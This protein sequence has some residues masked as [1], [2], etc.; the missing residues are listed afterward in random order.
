M[1]LRTC[2]SLTPPV[3]SLL[4]AGCGRRWRSG[5]AAADSVSPEDAEAVQ[6]F[7]AK[8][9]RVSIPYKSFHVTFQRSGGA[10]GQNV[11]KVST[12]VC[13]RF[14]L[15]AQAWLPDYVRRRLRELDAGRINTRGEYQITSERTRSQRQNIDDCLDRLWEQID[16]AAALPTAP[17]Q[18]TVE[19]VCSLK[20]AEKARDTEAKKR[21]S[22]RK[23]GRRDGAGDL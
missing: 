12:K 4:L 8:F 18:E 19:R 13:M 9:T 6:R 14:D 17:S 22:A 10:G 7:R 15:A 5:P 20:R 23:S 11:N 1:L 3:P 2:W 21:R 16:R